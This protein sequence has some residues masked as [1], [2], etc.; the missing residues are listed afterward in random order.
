M[1]LRNHLARRRHELGAELAAPGAVCE[2]LALPRRP[3]DGRDVFPRL[4]IARTVAVMHGIEDAQLRLPRSISNLQ[5]VG[6]TVVR[7]GDGLDARPEL[8][9]LGNEVVVGINH[10]K[11]GDALVVLRDIHG[12][13]SCGGRIVAMW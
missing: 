4:V 12:G 10:Q 6:D 2:G 8:A 1:L 9:A 3:L 13:P 7:L 5:H 11:C